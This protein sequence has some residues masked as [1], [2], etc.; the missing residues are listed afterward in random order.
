[1]PQ[2][3]DPAALLGTLREAL[4]KEYQ[5]EGFVGRGSFALLYKGVEK[6]PKR[7]VAIKVVPADAAE[8]LGER[9]RRE[10]RVGTNLVNA[11]IIPIYKVGQAAG[12]DYYTVKWVDGCTLDFVLAESGP[13]P[14]PLALSVLRSVARGL[15]YAHDRRVLHRDLRGAKVLVDRDGT[16][17]LADTG[18]AR[19]LREG[20][21]EASIGSPLFRSPEQWA[22]QQTVAQSDQYA[23][24]VLAYQM[25]VGRLP[26]EADDEKAL[27]ELHATATPPEIGQSRSDVPP[28][29]VE[30]VRKA[31]AKTPA[32]R[33]ATTREMLLAIQAV[34]LSDAEQEAAVQQLAGL[35]QRAPHPDIVT[36]PSAREAAAAL[37]VAP[38]AYIAPAKAPPQP[39][40]AAPPPPPP[41]PKPPAAPVAKPEPAP[42]ALLDFV[43]PP[44]PAPPPEPDLLPDLELVPAAPAA[45][46][47]PPSPEPV[48]E[49]APTPE[50]WHGTALLDMDIDEETPAAPTPPASPAPGVRAPRPTGRLQPL[51]APPPAPIT[52]E[53]LPVSEAPT[54]PP[55]PPMPPA[56]PPVYHEPP[57]PPRLEIEPMVPPAPAPP[58]PSGDR[59]G[60]GPPP[61]AQGGWDAPT[62][63][64]PP[65]MQ[66]P[67]PGLAPPPADEPYSPPRAPEPPPPPLRRSTERPA[68]RP[69]LVEVQKSPMLGRI[70]GIAA[71]V[72]VAVAA[73]LILG[74]RVNN[75]PNL[76][77]P[78]KDSLRAVARAESIAT[79]APVPTTGWV[80]LNGD[81]PDDA[82]IWL[83]NVKVKGLVFPAQPGRH[84]LQVVTDEFEPWETRVRVTLGDTLTVEVELV[85]I[86]QQNPQ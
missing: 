66:R 5:V 52:W 26:F 48:P 29:L 47:P 80:R 75:A 20:T 81:L 84:T 73:V 86:Q 60:W 49:D 3:T 61:G 67:S 62:A 27:L 33:Y 76:P 50:G 70:L 59:G 7:A 32:E 9:V 45:H 78:V 65:P 51:P 64:P 69:A 22:G 83:D 35:A 71:I 68:E 39:T 82:V 8:G 57:P 15:A 10:A 23:L 34:P 56:P 72:V 77:A 40:R 53:P 12:T 11:N 16:V 55:P 79:F 85:L 1:M 6:A 2:T 74:R 31:L 19:A 36:D 25:L 4:A 46:A 24:G 14:V 58:T 28:E 30:L 38:P 42:P 21:S 18:M 37:S 17:A 13:L 63:P 43:I 41:A 44:A 54:A